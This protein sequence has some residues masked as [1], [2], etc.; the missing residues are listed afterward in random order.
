MKNVFKLIAKAVL[1]KEFAELNTKK[2][3]KIIFDFLVF[4]T[5]VAIY[6]SVR[7]RN[8]REGKKWNN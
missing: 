1:S 2:Y 6:I 5:R 4:G 7:R 8:N 3:L